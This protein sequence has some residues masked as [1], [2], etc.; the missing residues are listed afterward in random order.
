M[1]PTPAPVRAQPGYA[2]VVF[3]LDGTLAD[4]FPFFVA[5]QNRLAAQHGF[6]PIADH[7][8]ERLRTWTP[9]Q[10]MRHTRLSPWKLPRVARDFRRMMAAEGASIGCFHGV[11]DALRQLHGSG[12]RLGLVSSNSRENCERVLGPASWALFSEVECGASLFGKARRLRRLLR[13]AGVSARD[14]IYVG[15]QATDAEA[16]RA[17]GMAFAAVA[18]GYATRDALATLAPD[19]LVE[20]AADLAGVARRR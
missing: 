11:H 6:R 12:A 2:L 18:W 14:A 17:V 16:A 5:C 19:V 4:S 13:R 10:L 20:R 8:V 1:V 3:D 9:R 7:E 15:D